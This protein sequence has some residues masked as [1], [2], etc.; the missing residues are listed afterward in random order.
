MVQDCVLHSILIA[1]RGDDGRCSIHQLHVIDPKRIADG[2][3]EWAAMTAVELED[4]MSGR[5]VRP[6]PS[7]FGD[8]H[9]LSFAVE[10][11]EAVVTARQSHGFPKVTLA[12]DIAVVDGKALPFLPV[13]V[14][15]DVM[16]QSADSQGVDVAVGIFPTLLQQTGH[17]SHV[18]S[19][20]RLSAAEARLADALAAWGIVLVVEFQCR[21][22]LCE[23]DSN[24]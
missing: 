18:L 7:F 19:A 1:G 2:T 23:G 8:G 4:D 22:L 17:L 10:G 21:G 14:L 15:A 24:R 16:S 13:C 20:D 11:I 6:G 5:F 3:D 9:I 12:G